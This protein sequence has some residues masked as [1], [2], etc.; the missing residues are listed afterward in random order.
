MAMRS[1]SVKRLF[2]DAVEGRSASRV[3]EPVD[4]SA[5]VA[6]A[7]GAEEENRKVL[8][9]FLRNT[10]GNL[11]LNAAWRMCD[12]GVYN[13]KACSVGWGRVSNES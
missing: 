9:S 7:S 12:V 3:C 5:R 2:V 8:I 10:C 6:M 13:A 11:G 1:V 4:E